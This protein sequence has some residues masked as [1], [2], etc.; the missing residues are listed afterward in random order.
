MAALDSKEFE[1][2]VKDIRNSYK[3]ITTDNI[4]NVVVSSM[5][6]VQKYRNISG[7][8]KK[9]TV[10]NIL[11]FIVDETH[12]NDKFDD[13]IKSMIPSVIDTIIEANKGKLMLKKSVKFCL[14]S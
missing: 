5:T 2:I 4:I 14:C 1:A 13:I 6:A 8:Q 10:I 3:E 12:Q 7:K 11:T 9:E